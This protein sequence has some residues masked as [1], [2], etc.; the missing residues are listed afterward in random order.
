MRPLPSRGAHSTV[1]PLVTKGSTVLCAPREGK[2]RMIGL[3]HFPEAEIGDSRKA[4]PAA[5]SLAASLLSKAPDARG[6]CGSLRHTVTRYRIRLE[7]FRF[8]SKARPRAPW[9]W[10]ELDALKALPL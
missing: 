8:H 6:K 4:A 3:W 7:A 5:L 1:L 10:V 9:R 2:G